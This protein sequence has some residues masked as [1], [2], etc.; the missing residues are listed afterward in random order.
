VGIDMTS[1]RASAEAYLM[2]DTCYLLRPRVLDNGKGG[3]KP[4]PAGPQR[5]GP[6]ICGFGSASG[7]EQN[8]AD[9]IAQR[10]SYRL[11]LPTLLLDPDSGDVITPAETDQFEVFA[12]IYDVKWLPPVAALSL[13][14][15]VGL[16][17]A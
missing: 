8:V 15:R 5:I 9:Q 1:P 12:R 2:G 16:E 7:R 13:F 6:F 14:R 4:D 17:E 11:R 10:G 3:T